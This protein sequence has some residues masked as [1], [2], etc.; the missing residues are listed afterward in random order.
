MTMAFVTYENRRNPHVTIHSAGCGQIGKNGGQHKYDQGAYRDHATYAEASGYSD[1][2]GLK[3]IVCSYCRPAPTRAGLTEAVAGRL[4]EELPERELREGA[5]YQVTVNAYERNPEA[6]R[7]CIA[8]H[9]TAC[10][11]CGFSF[12]AEYGPQA[13]GYIHVHHVRPLS[14][15]GGAYVVDPVEDLRPIC[16]N[17]HAVIH[18]GG[19]CR[20][21]DEVRQLRARQQHARDKDRHEL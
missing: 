4:P 17:C 7:L 21:I 18:L 2:T 10:S 14:A 11:I 1:T 16:P 5:V 19:R 9:G 15:V 12:G 6:R 3:V 20:S 13:D 8:T